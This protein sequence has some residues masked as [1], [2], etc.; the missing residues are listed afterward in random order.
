MRI[1]DSAQGRVCF[2]MP[3]SEAIQ[4]PGAALTAMTASLDL[5][6]SCS[7]TTGVAFWFW[8]LCF[9]LFFFAMVAA[10]AQS[11]TKGHRVTRQNRN[12]AFRAIEMPD[13]RQKPS[14]LLTIIEPIFA[15]VLR[16]KVD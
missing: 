5:R 8:L 2:S 9:L 11:E 7:Q 3:A 14:G 16:A 15:L 6:V 10:L 12:V 4:L 13:S 1:L